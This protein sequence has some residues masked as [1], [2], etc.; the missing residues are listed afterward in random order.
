MAAEET[1]IGRAGASDLLLAQDDLTSRHHALIKRAGERVLIFD[2]RSY[3]GVFIN[4]QKIEG[5]RGHE[6]ADGDHISI[7][8]YELIF[9]SALSKNVSRL[10]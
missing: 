7:G 2:K 8:N 6:L 4:G 1:N 9:R 3:N 10:V 5:E